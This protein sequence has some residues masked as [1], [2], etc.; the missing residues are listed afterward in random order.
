MPCSICGEPE[1]TCK[2]IPE[3]LDLLEQHLHELIKKHGSLLIIPLDVELSSE[4]Y[5]SGGQSCYRSWR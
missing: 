3:I 1:C 2:V 4:T 5:Y